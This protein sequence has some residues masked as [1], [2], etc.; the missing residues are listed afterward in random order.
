[1]KTE[2]ELRA[3]ITNFQ[4]QLGMKDHGWAL[5][6]E[7]QEIKTKIIIDKEGDWRAK[8]AEAYKLSFD[9]FVFEQS[10]LEN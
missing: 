2:Q 4:E 5:G 1:M 6:S 7:I 3:R 8:H 9:I 10:T